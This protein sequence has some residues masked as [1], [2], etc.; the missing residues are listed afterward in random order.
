MPASWRSE[1]QQNPSEQEVRDDKRPSRRWRWRPSTRRLLLL[2]DELS[3]AGRVSRFRLDLDTGDWVLNAQLFPLAAWAA[4]RGWQVSI[5]F[6]G[7]TLLELD[8]RLRPARVGWALLLGL[9]RPLPSTNN[10][11]ARGQWL[12]RLF[13]HPPLKSYHHEHGL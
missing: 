11:A 1:D 12:G 8:A 2:L 9:L 4:A 13:F 7:E 3:R 5:H 6:G 10:A